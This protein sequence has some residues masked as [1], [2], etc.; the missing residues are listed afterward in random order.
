MHIVRHAGDVKFRRPMV[1][2][3]RPA[4]LGILLAL[5]LLA[6]L[7]GCG[8][9]LTSAVAPFDAAELSRNPTLI[10][11]TTRKAANGMRARPWFGTERASGTFARAKLVPPDE[12]RFSLSSIGLGDWSLEA[13]EPVEHLSE[14]LPP[15]PERRDLLLYVH[16]FNTTFETAALDAARLSDGIR[17]RGETMVFSW[18][19]KAKLF[20][21]GYDRES[22]MWSRDALERVLSLLMASP[23]IGRIHLVAHSVGTMLSLESLRQIYARHGMA[24]TD[25]IGAVI[26]AS[27]DIDMD[28][29]A[30]S[31]ER[32][33]PLAPKITVI[34]ATN[35]RALAVAGWIAGGMTR[36][37]AAEKS[38][39]EQMGL[40]VIDA[41]TEGWGLINHDL[42]L[43]NSHIRLVIRRAVDG[44]APDHS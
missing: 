39:L 5:P 37:G 23:G 24:V 32:I 3:V 28:V 8:A 12:G 44:V 33:P 42:F 31:V 11:A 27:P 40:R 7:A 26:F 9:A 17:F 19:S 13:V 4:A 1:R 20:D 41:S 34:T 35:D 36:V 14:M 25:K 21:Y 22:A 43:S 6:A 16:G 18:P 10:V 29:F 2:P 30:S 15:G 38:R